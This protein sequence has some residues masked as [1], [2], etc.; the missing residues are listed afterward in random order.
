MSEQIHRH[1][2]LFFHRVFYGFSANIL[3][4]KDKKIK[5]ARFYLTPD[6]LPHSSAAPSPRTE[7][8]GSCWCQSY[9]KVQNNTHV[10]TTPRPEVKRFL[11]WATLE[12]T[13][14]VVPILERIHLLSLSAVL[15]SPLK[16]HKNEPRAH[17]SVL[18]IYR[19][20]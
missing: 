19:C 16:H 5:T 11:C 20:I 9:L 17:S 12:I 6:L 1:V 4:M 14:A 18:S 7:L 15:G 8:A 2:S 13:S 10:N 3:T